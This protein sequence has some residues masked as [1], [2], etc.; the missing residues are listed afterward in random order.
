VPNLTSSSSGDTAFVAEVSTRWQP[1]GHQHHHQHYQQ[2]L[3]PTVNLAL[4]TQYRNSDLVFRFKA[5]ITMSP[6]HFV[7]LSFLALTSHAATFQQ[8]SRAQGLFQ[9]DIQVSSPSLLVK[10]T[11]L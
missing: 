9:R 6:V 1:S 8:G 10:L 11:P 7:L 3:K 2:Q 5:D 4:T